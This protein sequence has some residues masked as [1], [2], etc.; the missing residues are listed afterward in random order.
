MASER[1]T[2]GKLIRFYVYKDK[3]SIKFSRSVLYE[4]DTH[5][6]WSLSATYDLLNPWPPADRWVCGW[7]EERSYS[8]SMS[9]CFHSGSPF[10]V[11]LSVFSI[12]IISFSRNL[13]ISIENNTTFQSGCLWNQKARLWWLNYS[14]RDPGIPQRK[15]NTTKLWYTQGW[16]DPE[17]ESWCLYGLSDLRICLSITLCSMN[18]CDMFV[19]SVISTK[20]S[21]LFSQCG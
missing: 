11:F 7:G 2:V 8:Q 14:V 10:S 17:W 21:I 20:P 19:H 12:S 3:T 6:N 16:Q 13:T 1:Q 9:L 18:S 5:T 4:H 15:V